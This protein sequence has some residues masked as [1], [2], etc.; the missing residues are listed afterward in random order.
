M[1]LMRVACAALLLLA[2]AVLGS[3]CAPP[4]YAEYALA[5]GA[6]VESV[7]CYD[8]CMQ[9][10][11]AEFR[12]S[13][14]ARCDGVVATKTAKPCEQLGRER[15]T[16]QALAQPSEPEAA[17]EYDEASDATVAAAVIGSL[18]DLLVFAA[19]SPPM[20]RTERS[21]QHVHEAPARPAP[22]I[23]A[24]PRRVPERERAEPS[25]DRRS[26]R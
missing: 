6:R 1:V 8:S 25:Q 18:F 13:C 12:Q 15:C 11:L 4:Y 16:W 5:E 10:S 19:N 26:T 2:L 24:R 9:S 21:E 3:A 23:P 22:R 20:K 7:Q 14:L 17:Y